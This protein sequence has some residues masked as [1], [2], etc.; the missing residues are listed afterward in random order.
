MNLTKMTKHTALV[1]MLMSLGACFHDDEDDKT[2]SQGNTN[3]DPVYSV[4]VT[5]LTNN[6]LITPLAVVIH[7]SGYTAWELGQKASPGLEMLAESG[8]PSTLIAEAQASNFVVNTAVANSVTPPNSSQTVTITAPHSHTLKISLAAMLADTNDAYTGVTDW[9][10][11]NLD[12]GESTSTMT[13]VYDA[14]TE[15]NTETGDTIPGPSSTV[16]GAGGYSEDNNDV[17]ITIHPGVITADDGLSNS[18][19]DESKRWLSYAAKIKVTR[20]N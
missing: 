12:V 2:M 9:L 20:T 15:A 1:V 4:V 16:G 13:R 5:N 6:Q 3:S 17:A 19:L 14:G 10:V 7:E 11:G 8:N 18:A